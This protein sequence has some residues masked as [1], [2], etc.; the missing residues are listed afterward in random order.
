MIFIALQKLHII[1][2]NYI[3]YRY[4]YLTAIYCICFKIDK[5]VMRKSQY[6]SKRFS[7]QTE[8]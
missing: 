4:T 6:F 7:K 5:S 8:Y 1:I 3:L 2:Y